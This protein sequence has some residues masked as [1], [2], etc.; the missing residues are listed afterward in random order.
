M[1]VIY[2]L[3]D[4]ARIQPQESG[5]RAICPGCRAE[6]LGKCGT[7]NVHHWA[8]LTSEDCDQWSEPE[9][10]WHK[11]WKSC[12]PPE[13]AEVVVGNHRADILAPCGWVIEL[14]H[15]TISADEIIERERFYKR[16][17]W[18]VD[19]EPF[20]ENFHLR[21]KDENYATFR[22]RW[23]RKTW[24][25]ARCPIYLHFWPA[26]LFRI[27]K[28]YDLGGWGRFVSATELVERAT[29]E[30]YVQE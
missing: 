9:T 11:M 12:F 26:T 3:V 24:Q 5:Q 14:Q 28:L 27:K 2:A 25:Y 21:P 19:A 30:F 22:W 13:C 6:V 17:I 4:G 10:P 1:D 29:G 20:K 18:I 16:M 7:I 8:H 23:S 15:S